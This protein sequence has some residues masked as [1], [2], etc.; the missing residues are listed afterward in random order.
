MFADWKRRLEVAMTMAGDK[1]AD[2]DDARIG[3]D[4]DDENEADY[5]KSDYCFAALVDVAMVFA[6]RAHLKCLCGIVCEVD[7]D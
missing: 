7:T 1:D 2:G 3:D 5:G 4:D 6:K